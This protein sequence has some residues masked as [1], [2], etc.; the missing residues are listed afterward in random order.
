MSKEWQQE[1]NVLCSLEEGS[2]PFWFG[3]KLMLTNNTRYLK[4]AFC[5]KDENR[6]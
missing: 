3:S 1:L 5:V 4:A 2:A 6:K